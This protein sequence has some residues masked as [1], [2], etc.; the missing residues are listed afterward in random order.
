VERYGDRLEYLRFILSSNTTTFVDELERAGAARAQLLTM[1]TPYITT[2]DVPKQLP[3]SANSSWA[4]PIAQRCATTQTSHIPL[5]MLTPQEA[6]IHAAVENTL[7]EICRRLVLV[8]IELVDVEAA[9]EAEAAKATEMARRHISELMSWLGW[10]VWV[11]CSP[12]CSLGVRRL[13]LC[14]S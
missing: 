8:W 4:A 3:P 10:T 7:R 5:G 12:G 13:I 6:R 1:L 11:R 14:F 9:D 2:V